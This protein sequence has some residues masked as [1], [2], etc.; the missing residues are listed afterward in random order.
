M[1]W[2]PSL[3]SGPPRACRLCVSA[4]HRPPASRAVPFPA[5]HARLS[6][7]QGATAFNQLLSFD[8]S[9]VTTMVSMFYV[10]SAR[11]LTFSIELGPPRARHL[12]RR[13]PTP[14]CLSH[15]A[16]CC[17][18]TSPRI[19]CPPFDSAQPWVG[20]SPCTPLALPPPHAL[21]PHITCFTFDSAGDL[22]DVSLDV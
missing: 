2:P 16:R 1:P 5:S 20:P 6:T 3:E 17:T 10:R 4:T 19:A 18:R 9:K 8:T 7:R 12:R 11:A 15:A 14:S 13:H 22:G 21:S